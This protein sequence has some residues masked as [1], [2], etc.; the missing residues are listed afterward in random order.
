[1]AIGH[2]VASVSWFFTESICSPTFRNSAER[3]RIISHNKNRIIHDH[4]MIAQT[5]RDSQVSNG[6]LSAWHLGTERRLSPGTAPSE[7]V[8]GVPKPG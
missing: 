3:I 8:F 4:E 1:M 6:T 5:R 7:L 2:S